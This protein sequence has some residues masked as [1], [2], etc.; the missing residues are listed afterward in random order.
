MTKLALALAVACLMPSLG[1]AATSATPAVNPSTSTAVQWP[2]YHAKPWV[3]VGK[4]DDVTSV[5]NTIAR[6]DYPRLMELISKDESRGHSMIRIGAERIF[7]NNSDPEKVTMEVS[8]DT[9]LL[10]NGPMLKE[11]V[12][13][14]VLKRFYRDRL[15]QTIIF[16][17]KVNGSWWNIS[18]EDDVAYRVVDPY[19][20]WRDSMV[21]TDRYGEAISKPVHFMSNEKK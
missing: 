11:V 1:N 2:D 12:V 8:E 7:D 9:L 17:Q 13:L 18:P 19:A 16:Q 21:V 10:A 4:I 3:L 14:R 6:D 5:R 15:P 20:P